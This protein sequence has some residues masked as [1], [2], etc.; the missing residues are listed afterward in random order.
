[1]TRVKKAALG[2]VLVIASLLAASSSALEGVASPASTTAAPRIASMSTDGACWETADDDAA[3][4]TDVMATLVMRAILQCGP[5]L[6]LSVTQTRRV[7]ELTDR[8]MR[9]SAERQT[10]LALMQFDLLAMLRPHPRDP[11]RPVDVKV[12]ETKIREIARLRA[13]QDVALVRAIEAIKAVLTA[14]QRGALAT[15]LSSPAATL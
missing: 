5:E 4:P 14:G 10:R 11:A 7:H 13:E 15:L 12:A 8:F 9:E 3:D 1:M 6:G 2:T